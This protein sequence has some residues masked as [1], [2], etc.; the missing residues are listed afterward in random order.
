[1]INF[2]IDISDLLM[3]FEELSS[4]SGEF[5]N[6]L[7][8]KIEK[9]FTFQ[10]ET[11]INKDLKGTRS[12]YKK[13]IY[14]DYPEEGVLVMGLNPRESQLA[15]MIEDGA[16]SWDMTDGFQKSKNKTNKAN[17]GWYLTIPF[18]HATSEAIGESNI[19]SNKMTPVV[20]AEVKRQGTLKDLSKLPEEYSKLMSNPTTGTAHKSPIVQGIRR[21][22][23]SSSTKENRGGY[24]S[25]RRVSDNSEEG[26]W[27]HPGFEARKFMEQT[28]KQVPFDTIVA[29]SID[30]F[31][32][33]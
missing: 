31:L 4:K 16:S 19:F 8:K 1:M 17:G 13:A 24:T 33:K 3:E 28:M 18:K 11:N 29:E 27:I 9:E 5:K 10:W 15:L 14:V 25:F 32:M 6:Y 30:E 2:Q 22:D 20:Q 26:S 23:V 7:L 21:I 12:E